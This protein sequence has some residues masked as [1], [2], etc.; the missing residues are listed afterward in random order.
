MNMQTRHYEYADTL[1]YANTLFPEQKYCKCQLIIIN[2][3]YLQ[4]NCL[5]LF[6]GSC[7][8]NLERKSQAQSRMTTRWNY[9]IIIILN[10]SHYSIESND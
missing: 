7:H 3:L 5:F 8:W 10:Q 2:Y 4:V 9:L 6:F 1:L